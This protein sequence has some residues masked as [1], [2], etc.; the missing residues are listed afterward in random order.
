M[1]SGNRQPYLTRVLEHIPG[2]TG[3]PAADSAP[4]PTL[5]PQ[6]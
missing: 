3:E 1:E 6:P 2:D 4:H 5:D